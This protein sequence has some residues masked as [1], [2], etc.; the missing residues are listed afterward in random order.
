ME[1]IGKILKQKLK[2]I[3]LKIVA[4][5]IIIAGS[6]VIIPFIIIL[7]IFWDYIFWV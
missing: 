2:S 3:I 7:W 1:K 5:T 4:I 6:P